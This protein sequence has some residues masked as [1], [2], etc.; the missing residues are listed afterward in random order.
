MACGMACVGYACGIRRAEE[1]RGIRNQGT[2]ALRGGGEVGGGGG[3]ERRVGGVY[4]QMG[5]ITH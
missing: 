1:V 3:V 5:Y 2:G 4:V